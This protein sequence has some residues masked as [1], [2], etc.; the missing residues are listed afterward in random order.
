MNRDEEKRAFGLAIKLPTDEGEPAKHLALRLS[1]DFDDLPQTKIDSLCNRYIPDFLR[2]VYDYLRKSGTPD[3]QHTAKGF[4]VDV[5]HGEIP[6]EI[7]CGPITWEERELLRLQLQYHIGNTAHTGD[8]SGE[9]VGHKL[10]EIPPLVPVL[11]NT[12]FEMGKRTK[13]IVVLRHHDGG[14]EFEVEASDITTIEFTVEAE[15]RML[16]KWNKEELT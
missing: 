3:L 8:C 1:I 11:G 9:I 5:K 4:E 7:P 14:A 10:V 16:A 6:T 2:E 15:S 12:F 13:S